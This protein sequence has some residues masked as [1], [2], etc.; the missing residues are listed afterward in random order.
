MD[1]DK[2][3]NNLLPKSIV[4][5]VILAVVVIVAVF[6]FPKSPQAPDVFEKEK[7]SGNVPLLTPAERAKILEGLSGESSAKQSVRVNSSATPVPPFLTP[8]ERAK[9][10]ESLKK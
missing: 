4:I 1:I 2:D 10:L 6:W 3:K 5:I 8:K 9:I 7:I